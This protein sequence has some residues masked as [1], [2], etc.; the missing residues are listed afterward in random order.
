MFNQSLSSNVKTSID[1][2]QQNWINVLF[3]CVT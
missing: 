3:K 2:K 1:L